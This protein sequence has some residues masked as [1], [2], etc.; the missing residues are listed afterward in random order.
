VTTVV[1]HRQ[2]L[3]DG[4]WADGDDG[5]IEVRSPHSSELA[6]TVAHCTPAQVD[7]AVAA[8]KNAFPAWKK[9]PL[10]DRVDLLYKAYDLCK[11]RNEAIARQI[12][13]EMGKTI[14]E[15]REEMV[16]YACEH[17]RRA[18][19]DVLQRAVLVH[20]RIQPR[21]DPDLASGRGGVAL[22][23]RV[24]VADRVGAVFRHGHQRV[25][26]DHGVHPGDPGLRR[27]VLLRRSPA[28]LGIAVSPDA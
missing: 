7:Q 16:E 15:S 14:R 28:R 27:G 10:L 26:R 19:E 11:E 2:A 1:T 17:F 22:A 23:G 24:D 18:S 8:A 20:R 5:V 6:G 3:I 9:T 25:Q 4:R 12:S 21:R 13:L